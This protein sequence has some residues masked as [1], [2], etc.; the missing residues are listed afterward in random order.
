MSKKILQLFTIYSSS[1][2][3]L[4]VEGQTLTYT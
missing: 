2:C 3:V 1:L 4:E